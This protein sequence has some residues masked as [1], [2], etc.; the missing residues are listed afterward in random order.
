M[1]KPS[2][3]SSLAGPGY[4][5]LNII[6]VINIITFL[7][8]ITA[9]IVVLASIS[10]VNNAFIFFEAVT[11]A[12]IVGIVGESYGI[13]SLSIFSTFTVSSQW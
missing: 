4:I 1:M 8:I 3:D 13:L 5:L 10:A 11:H 12:M 2:K 7:D 9:N 6:R